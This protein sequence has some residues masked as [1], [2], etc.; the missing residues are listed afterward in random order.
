MKRL[1]NECA[2]PFSLTQHYIVSPRLVLAGAGRG[3]SPSRY[4]LSMT[5]QMR[6][7]SMPR[8]STPA[9]YGAKR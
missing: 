7:R 4:G 9:S 5:G 6:G 3:D 8:I 2:D 1:S